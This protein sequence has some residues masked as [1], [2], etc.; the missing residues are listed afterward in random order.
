MSTL[1]TQR[2]KVRISNL[3]P[4]EAQLKDQ[5]PKKSSRKPSRKSKTA[6]PTNGKKSDNPKKKKRKAQLKIPDGGI[7]AGTVVRRCSGW[8]HHDN[9]ATLI[10]G[11]PT[12][13]SPD[14][15]VIIN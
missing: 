4:H 9:K 11:V 13:A 6:K 3:R 1:T 7:S 12:G 15:R 2:H 8:G 5:K 14:L 10:G